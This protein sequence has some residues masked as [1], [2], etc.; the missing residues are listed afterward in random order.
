MFRAL[1]NAMHS[2]ITYGSRPDINVLR[3]MI[4]KGD[5]HVGS[6]RSLDQ[7]TEENTNL[8]QLLSL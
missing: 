5:G 3:A 2:A 7:S 1:L 6:F 4:K 8:M